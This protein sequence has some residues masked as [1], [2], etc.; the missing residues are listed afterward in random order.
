M[1]P[2]DEAAFLR[3]QMEAMQVFEQRHVQPEPGFEEEPTA[4]VGQTAFGQAAA[5]TYTLPGSAGLHHAST[6]DGPSKAR[7]TP[8]RNEQPVGETEYV[9]SRPRDSSIVSQ[10]DILTRLVTLACARSGPS[11]ITYPLWMP[12]WQRFLEVDAGF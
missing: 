9:Q 1:E 5:A 4:S 10:G 12:R 3:A 6:T 7:G 2:D 11:S 8:P